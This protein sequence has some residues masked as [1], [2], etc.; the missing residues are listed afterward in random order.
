MDTVHA[1]GNAQT[2]ASPMPVHDRRPGKGTEDKRAVE[3]S[4]SSSAVNT[5]DRRSVLEPEAPVVRLIRDFAH[6]LEATISQMEELG[7]AEAA[8]ENVEDGSGDGHLD[9]YA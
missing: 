8:G 3:H 6:H 5:E 9:L 7:S 1:A 2:V 4:T